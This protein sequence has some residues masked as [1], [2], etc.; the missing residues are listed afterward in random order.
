MRRIWLIFSQAV[1]VTVAVLFVLTTL[2]PEWMG[3]HGI[4][5]LPEVVT[6]WQA[7]PSDAASRPAASG[8]PPGYVAAARSASPAV[9]SITASRP[10][11]RAPVDPSAG[12]DDNED[13]D[14]PLDS[15]A[16]VGSGVIA[17][18]DGYVLTNHHVIDGADDIE[19]TLADGR[20]AGARV[21]GSDAETDLAV[22][23]IDLDKLP[24]ITFGHSDALQVGE[25]VLAIGNPFGVGQTVTAGIV[26]AL[27]RTNGQYIQTD[28]AINP[29]NSGGAL[30]DLD[31][32][33]V[34]LNT[35]ILSP[36][37]A[38]GTIANGSL[39]GN[40]GI[41]FA[42]PSRTVQ[43]VLDALIRDGQ[44]VRGWIGVELR[45]VTPEMA[46]ALK[47]PRQNGALITGVLQGGPAHGAGLQPGDV[48]V[49]LGGTAVPDA[50][51]LQNAVSAL[52]PAA[53]ARATVLRGDRQLELDLQV[54][55]RPKR[56]TTTR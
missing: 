4:G 15:S 14:P 26:S 23:R 19:V 37:T 44:V 5:A 40:L 38:S 48:V 54:A 29:G 45:D 12:D 50:R 56:E 55:E 22:L 20:S 27:D 49:G 28:A 39:R 10:G 41:G 6:V 30:V 3:R 11:A 51:T 7:P 16:G 2:K 47:L 1:T 8:T 43:Q 35:A 42:I 36:G 13:D 17:S 18:P 52:R 32:R 31:G 46:E 25:I 21:V 34:G 33:L 9:V 53:K 24:A